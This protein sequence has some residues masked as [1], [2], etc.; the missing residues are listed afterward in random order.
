MDN[1]SVLDDHCLVAFLNV[2]YLMGCKND[3]LRPAQ[4]LD[5]LLEDL[6]SHARID[7]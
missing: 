2:T 1:L 5:A 7:C 6:L 4:R 3:G